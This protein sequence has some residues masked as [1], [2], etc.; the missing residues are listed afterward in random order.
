[1]SENVSDIALI[2]YGRMGRPMG[3]R[4]LDAQLRLLVCDV[5]PAARRAAD[6]DGAVS[7]TSAAEAA[8]AARTI[9]T[10]LPDPAATVAACHGDLGVLA[11]LGRGAL[12]LEMSSS[13]PATTQ[14]LARAAEARGA[15]L[16]DAPVSGGVA[17]AEEGTLAILVGG[18]AELLERAQP[19]LQLLGRDI[20]HVGDRPGDGDL[21]KTL[22][23]LLSAVNLTAAAE[24]VALGVRGG[25]DPNRLV[26]A[27]GAGTGSSRA[28]T[29]KFPAQVLSG[30][31]GAGFTIGQMLKDLGIARDVAAGLEVSTPVGSLVEDL[32]RMFGDEGHATQDHTYVAALVAARA[33]VEIPSRP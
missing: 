19:I 4:L 7:V 13:L 2:G 18:P 17:G 33:G 24:A 22:N 12:W 31:F 6:H 3:R 30:A 1:M 21:A 5:D 20:F 10:M 28:L 32:W 29:A 15:A 14:D 23:N 27:I 11:G 8:A 25:L 9:I 16:L 26:A